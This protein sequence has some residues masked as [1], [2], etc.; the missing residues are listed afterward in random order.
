MHEGNRA[1]R[2]EDWKLVSRSQGPWELYNL[3]ED[4]TELNDLAQAKPDMLENLVIYYQ[5]TADRCGVVPY[6]RLIGG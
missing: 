3:R 4:R 5:Q 2:I 6:E 1:A